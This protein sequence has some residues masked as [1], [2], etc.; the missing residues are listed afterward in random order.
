MRISQV[1]NMHVV[2][3]ARAVSR[4]VIIAKNL[5]GLLPAHGREQYLRDQMLFGVM[6][7]AYSP[8]RV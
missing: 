4:R 3:N 8:F 2:P 7:F 5:E 6:Q 1:A